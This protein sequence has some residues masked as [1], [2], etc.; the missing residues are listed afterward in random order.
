MSSPPC[1]PKHTLCK[2]SAWQAALLAKWKRSQREQQFTSWI[3]TCSRAY[4][5]NDRQTEACP[6]CLLAIQAGGGPEILQNACNPAG[7]TP[8][9]HTRP[10]R[11]GCP[12]SQ[13]HECGPLT[14]AHE[15]ALGLPA[16]GRLQ[17]VADKPHVPHCELPNITATMRPSYPQAPK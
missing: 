14:P 16:Q 3:T 15:L 12:R 17:C 6:H 9:R 11:A 7:S 5:H 8:E 13:P 10:R 2:C 4:L 1:T